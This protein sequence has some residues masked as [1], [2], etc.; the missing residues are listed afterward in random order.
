MLFDGLFQSR[1]RSSSYRL[2]SSCWIQFAL[3]TCLFRN[4]LGVDAS[5]SES[6]EF[7]SGKVVRAAVFHVSIIL[8]LF[9]AI[10]MYNK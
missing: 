10:C 8:I 7:M 5:I 3:L 1:G 2:V 4:D 6:K 9:I